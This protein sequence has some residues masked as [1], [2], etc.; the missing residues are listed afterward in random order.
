MP[1]VKGQHAVVAGASMAGLLAARVLSG[2]FDRV[3]VLE[4]DAVVDDAVA[5]KGQPHARHVHAL[6]AQGFRIF[7]RFFPNLRDDLRDGGAILGDMGA[8]VRWHAY[9]GYRRQFESGMTGALASRPFLEACVRRRVQALPNV[10]I[11]GLADVDEPVASADRARITGLQLKPRNGAAAEVITADLV[12]DATGRGS[13]TPRWM[14]ALGYARPDESAVKINMGYSTRI[15]RR[16]AGDLAGAKLVLISPRLPDLARSGYVFPIEGDRWIVTLGGWGGDYPPTDEQGFLDHARS[17]AAPDVFEILQRLEPQGDII[18]HRLPSN[19]R[20][21]YETLERWPERYLVL[22]DAVSSFNPVY[23]QGMTSAAMQAVVLDDVLRE[24]TRAGLDG[25]RQRYFSRVA[26]VVD[27][28][29]LLAVSEDFRATTTTGPKPRG[30]DL[31]N[32]YVARVHRAT[33]VDAAVHRAF[34]D[35]MNLVK[36]ATSLMRPDIAWRVLRAS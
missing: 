21:H 9:G 2:H 19:L 13:A 11:R 33:Q 28:P 8:D 3:T 18:Q 27:R 1:E 35:V 7:E 17:L 20:R 36:P 5:R 10:T 22:G 29:W 31:V 14:E 24:R 26:K 15:F 23:A 4:R 16:R 30:T 12:V 32:P 34:L 25:L 6:L